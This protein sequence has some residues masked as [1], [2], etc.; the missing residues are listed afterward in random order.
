MEPIRCTKYLTSSQALTLNLFGPLTEDKGWAAR[1]LSLALGRTD[2]NTV[3]R[4]WI[5]FA[6]SRRSKFLN[7]MTRIDAV[8]LLE[9]SS[10]EE[11]LAIEVKYADRFSSRRVRI[12][13][14]PYRQLA[15]ETGLWQEPSEAFAS[16]PVN[17][18]VR[19]HGLAAALS[20]E[21][22]GQTREPTLLVL[23][24][25]EDN[26]SR[27]VIDRYKGH[28]AKSHLCREANLDE[29]VGA[30]AATSE[31]DGQRSLVHAIQARYVAEEQ[32]E[33]A[34]QTW[35][36]IAVSARHAP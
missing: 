32:S 27:L 30:L 17:Q 19:C 34:W 31:T 1:S 25:R 21:W 10:G 23:H 29:F 15:S 14:A 35:K 9:T 2:I 5:E 26:S 22:L 6:P 18:L 8:V 12:D 11:I 16:Q 4:I 13:R 7:D 24:H 33:A 28:L 3:R 36:G 20:I